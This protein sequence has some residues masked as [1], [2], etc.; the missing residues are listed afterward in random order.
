MPRKPESSPEQPPRPPL[1]NALHAPPANRWSFIQTLRVR[2]YE[3]DLQGILNN[4]VYQNYFEHNRNTFMRRFDF[5]LKELHDRG[6]DFVVSEV[7]IRYQTPLY[8]HDLIRIRLRPE[9]KG[10]LRFVFHQE[11]FV[12]ERRC[13]STSAETTVVCLRNGRPIPPEEFLPVLT[14]PFFEAP[15]EET[16]SENTEKIDGKA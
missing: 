2:D 5:N 15:R 7:L 13:V 16:D 9:K 1:K 11:I 8:P 4:A 12:P 14:A 6:K 10:R 3:C